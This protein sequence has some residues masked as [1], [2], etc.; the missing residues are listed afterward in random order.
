[1]GIAAGTLVESKK[2]GEFK[3]KEYLT[4]LMKKKFNG[5]MCVTIKGVPAV[6]ANPNPNG[7]AM[8]CNGLMK[9]L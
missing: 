1:M 2:L 5:Y 6:P 9:S 8:N 4:K 3:A 7:S